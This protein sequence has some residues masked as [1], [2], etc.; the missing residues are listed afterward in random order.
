MANPIWFKA[1]RY[2]YGWYPSTWQ[3]CF[4]LLAW[5]ALLALNAWRLM[6]V[7]PQLRTH[8]LEF[9]L[10]TVLMAAV[11]VYICYKTGEPARWR[12]GNDK[13]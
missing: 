9:G 12:W 2:G 5:V 6:S 13:K 11:L 7:D 10:E 3:G 4:I 8:G 1:K